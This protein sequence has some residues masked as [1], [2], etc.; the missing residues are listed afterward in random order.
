MAK[1]VIRDF[2]ERLDGK[3]QEIEGLLPDDYSLTL[4]A[5]HKS[6]RKAH[7]MLSMDDFETVIGAIGDLQGDDGTKTLEAR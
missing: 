2:H 4:I 6:N 3:L 1:Q 5:R 7:I